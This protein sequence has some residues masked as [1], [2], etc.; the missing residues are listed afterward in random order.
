MSRPSVTRPLQRIADEV[1][2]HGF[3]G[4]GNVAAS[5]RVV[6]EDALR[7][8]MVFY[9]DEHSAEVL[10]EPGLDVAV[11]V[12]HISDV[13][14]S[15]LRSGLSVG[16]ELVGPASESVVAGHYPWPGP[17]GELPSGLVADLPHAIAV[18]EEF[19]DPRE[20]V[21]WMVDPDVLVA[22]RRV[23]GETQPARRLIPAAVI[24]AEIG[25]HTLEEM[26]V[27]QARNLPYGRERRAMRHLVDLLGERVP[28]GLLHLL[29]PGDR[30]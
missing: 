24:A 15:P 9:F 11:V 25:D 5:S 12:E 3:A 29:P 19:E 2:K 7:R 22:G 18:L 17:G 14:L 4:R 26:V 13:D 23:P 27:E 6:R 10:G 1:L 20:L 28:G 30:R 16:L 8:S 21:R